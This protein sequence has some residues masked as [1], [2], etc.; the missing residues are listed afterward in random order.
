MRQ[1]TTICDHCCSTIDENTDDPQNRS[2]TLS[3]GIQVMI[4]VQLY[5]KTGEC[6]TD[7]CGDCYV[8]L[9]TRMINCVKER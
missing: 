5:T 8:H 3:D 1:V 7:L 9:L 6:K 2:F 4:Q